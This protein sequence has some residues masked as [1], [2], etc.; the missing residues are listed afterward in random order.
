MS[1]WKCLLTAQVMTTICKGNELNRQLNTQ[2]ISDS[3]L[4][5]LPK[6]EDIIMS[7][8]HAWTG[9]IPVQINSRL[10]SEP[11]IHAIHK[12]THIYN[13]MDSALIS[14][15][16]PTQLNYKLQMTLSG[17]TISMTWSHYKNS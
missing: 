14:L 10:L 8:L 9:A 7:I 13:G 17:G 16:I 11:L 4:L 2:N 5:S 15:F 3:F 1:N 6:T 12:H